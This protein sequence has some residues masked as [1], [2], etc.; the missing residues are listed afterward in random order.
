MTVVSDTG[1]K[2]DAVYHFLLNSEMILSFPITR[3]ERTERSMLVSDQK[4]CGGY[5]VADVLEFYIITFN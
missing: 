3:Q 2:F 4:P 5:V 1:P